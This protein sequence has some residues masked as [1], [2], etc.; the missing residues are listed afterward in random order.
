MVIRILST[1]LSVLWTHR[2]KIISFVSRLIFL[3]VQKIVFGRNWQFC[4][5]LKLLS[6]ICSTARYRFKQLPV[7]KK[8]SFLQV[9]SSSAPSS[10]TFFSRPFKPVCLFFFSIPSLFQVHVLNF[11]QPICWGLLFVF[12]LWLGGHYSLLLFAFLRCYSY[13]F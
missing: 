9:I 6:Q 8:L 12:G 1:L 5:H 7:S 11:I 10:Q 4:F 13:K 2:N 3:E